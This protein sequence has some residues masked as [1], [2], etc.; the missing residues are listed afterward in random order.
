MERIYYHDGH[1]DEFESIIDG[2]GF[3]EIAKRDD[4]TFVCYCPWCKKEVKKVGITLE[5]GRKEEYCPFCR[6]VFL[7]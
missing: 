2:I 1:F 4:G 7:L 3:A 5:N 6:Q